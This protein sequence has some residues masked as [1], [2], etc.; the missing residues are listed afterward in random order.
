MDIIDPLIVFY[1][2]IVAA[3]I[4]R[5]VKIFDHGED[6]I[7]IK[8]VFYI[9][10]PLLVF[11]SI[12]SVPLE[13]IL[14]STINMMI[15]SLYTHLI[16]LIII[17]IVVHF[18]RIPKKEKG[19]I[20]L[21]STF[22]N[23]IFLPLPLSLL[24][25][26]DLG[27]ILVTFY[28]IPALILFNFLGVIIG[29]IYSDDQKIDI[30]SMFKSFGK[31]P[32]LWAI[33]IA[34]S[35]LILGVKP[36]DSVILFS[37]NLGSIT[38]PIILFAIGIKL[39]LDFPKTHILAITIVSLIRIIISPIIVFGFLSVYQVNSTERFIILLESIM[40]PAVANAAFASVF[41]L[42][43]KLTAKVVSSVTLFSIFALLL[44]LPL[45]LP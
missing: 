21:T 23:A 18:L 17:F 15:A 39:K 26:G 27:V 35:A 43:D 1:G 7:L 2:T 11:H 42:D 20:V 29:V 4:A 31:F 34:S 14:S 10:Y 24:I 25:L 13:E 30:K 28:A 44:F 33:I 3:S 37:K 45:I 41:K 5:K 19:V 16:I 12:I 9:T 36:P 6:E 22:L 40:P 8:F 32:P 38:V